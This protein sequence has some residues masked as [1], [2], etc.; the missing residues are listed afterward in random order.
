MAMTPTL[1]ALKAKVA[2]RVNGDDNYEVV[3]KFYLHRGL[4]RISLFVV[5]GCNQSSVYH[6]GDY[7]SREEA[8]RE[9]YRLNGWGEPK[10]R[11]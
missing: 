3:H 1:Q 2:N 10:P 5:R 11:K 7:F 6:C 4:W 9:T 8:L